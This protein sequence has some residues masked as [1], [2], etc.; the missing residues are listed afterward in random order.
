MVWIGLLWLRI[1]R[2]EEDEFVASLKVW[3]GLV[4]LRNQCRALVSTLLNLWVL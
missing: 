3:T 2:T 4:F 1:G